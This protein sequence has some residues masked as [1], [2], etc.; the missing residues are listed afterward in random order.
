MSMAKWMNSEWKNALKSDKKDRQKRE[1]DQNK[2]IKMKIKTSYKLQVDIL[3]AFIYNGGC[4]GMH[5]SLNT[6]RKSSGMEKPGQQ[7][8]GKLSF[9]STDIQA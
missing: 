1:N 6:R 3:T 8:N 4:K 9:T 7:S 2:Q 5:A